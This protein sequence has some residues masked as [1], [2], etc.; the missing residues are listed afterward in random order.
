MVDLVLILAEPAPSGEILQREL[1]EAGFLTLIA[2]TQ[3]IALACLGKITPRA[4]LVDLDL[5]G[6]EGWAFLRTRSEDERLR[7][8]PALVL[9]GMAG[10]ALHPDTCALEKPVQRG[11][12]VSLLQVLCTVRSTQKAMG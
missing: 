4:I 7:G 8:I 5:P 2:P 12:L 10:L 1:H 11:A 9:S 3:R 6:D